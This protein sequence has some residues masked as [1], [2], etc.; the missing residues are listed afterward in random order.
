MFTTLHFR[1]SAK[2]TQALKDKQEGVARPKKVVQDVPTRWNSSFYM[3]ERLLQIHLPIVAVLTD[4]KVSKAAD[5][6]LDLTAAQWALADALLSVLKPFETATTLLSTD[7]NVSLSS[8]IPIMEGLLRKIKFDD[9]DDDTIHEVKSILIDQLSTRFE[10]NSLDAGSLPVMA[11]AV[12]PRFKALRFFSEQEDKKEVHQALL[13]WMRAETERLKGKAAADQAKATEPPAKKACKESPWDVVGV[14]FDAEHDVAATSDKPEEPEEH[15]LQRYLQCPPL[16]P[17][18]SP[19][20]WWKLKA[21]SYPRIAVV[22]KKV[23]S[24]P[25]TSTSSERAFSAGGLVACQ[26][27]A[28]L[29]PSTVDAIVFLN[30]NMR[31]LF[32]MTSHGSQG[33]EVHVKVEPA[34]GEEQPPLPSLATDGWEDM[35]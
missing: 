26:Q 35:S 12:D 17:N 11:S 32:N 19:L 34:D 29:S 30:K 10:L 16:A 23:L 24:V 21:E 1:H 27:C 8:V 18:S 6:E 20:E 9:E 2:A 15:E 33:T 31:T 14:E 7:L 5:V 4:K 3:L 28:A 22:A 13:T 25:A